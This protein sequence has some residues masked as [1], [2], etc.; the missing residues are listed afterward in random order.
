M[1]VR[2][3]RWIQYSGHKFNISEAMFKTKRKTIRGNVEFILH[4]DRLVFNSFS[5]FGIKSGEMVNDTGQCCDYFVPYQY[6]AWDTISR[7][8]TDNNAYDCIFAVTVTASFRD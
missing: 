5:D 6:A 2:V 1:C 7:L 8:A 3:N 4:D